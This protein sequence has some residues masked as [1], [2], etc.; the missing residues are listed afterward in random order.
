VPLG[1]AAGKI[2]PLG[3]AIVNAFVE[4]QVTVY[5]KGQGLPSLQ[6][7]ADINFRFPSR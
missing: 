3:G 5:H 7:F 1:L 2:L 6:I 4:P